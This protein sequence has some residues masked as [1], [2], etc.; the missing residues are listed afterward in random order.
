[1]KSFILMDLIHIGNIGIEEDYVYIIGGLV[2]FIIISYCVKPIIY[3]AIGL[4]LYKF[5]GYLISSIFTIL[6]AVHL[7]LFIENMNEMEVMKITLQSVSLYGIIFML[8][9]MLKHFIRR[10]N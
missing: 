5:L 3:W 8:L 6:V 9:I 2:G 4:K 1:L 7:S 10:T